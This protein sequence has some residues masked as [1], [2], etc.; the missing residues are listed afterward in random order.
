MKHTPISELEESVEMQAEYEF[1]YRQARL[2][3]FAENPPLTV[4]LAPDVARVFT[5]AEAVNLA[6]RAL[7]SALPVSLLQSKP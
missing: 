6:L 4:T 2:N 1:D 7:L 5:S 3:R